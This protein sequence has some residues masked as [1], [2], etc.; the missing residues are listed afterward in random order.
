[1]DIRTIRQLTLLLS[2]VAGI[3]AC[4]TL[5]VRTGPVPEL[6]SP[7]EVTP[8]P[9][10]VP[11]PVAVQP[12]QQ[13]V[14]AVPLPP[15][16]LPPSQRVRKALQMLEQGEY[17]DARNQLN[18]ALQEKPGLQIADNLIQQIDAD[19]I[20]YLGVKNFYY[21]VESGDSLSTIAG[22]FLED[23]MKFVVLARYNK[24]ENPSKLAPGDR[25]R[26]PGAMPAD[27]WHKPKQKKKK[28]K[29]QRK[30]SIPPVERAGEE[31]PSS[32]RQPIDSPY[33]DG[34]D[35]IGSSGNEADVQ[36]VEMQPSP[37][38][39]ATLDQVLDKA[40]KLYA[41]GDLPAAISQLDSEG[42]R[43]ASAKAVQS[44]QIS[45]Y[46][47]YAKQL[48]R[49]DELEQARGL[50]EK[51]VLLDA[52]DEQAIKNLIQ[53]EDKLEARRLYRLGEDLLS[54]EQVENAY[55]MFTQS[56]TYDPTNEKARAAQGICRDKLTDGYH[57]EAMRHF[58]NQELAQAIVLWDKI[59]ALD[60]GHPLAP[61]YRARAMEMQLKLKQIESNNQ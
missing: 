32:P 13:T 45:Y 3:S 16:R 34:Q 52:A 36:Q 22:K 8:K 43:Y 25:I 42:G 19:P 15:D 28:K 55:A 27:L 40:R 5:V 4:Q 24:L 10:P 44:L 38:P 6:D 33:G 56:L 39:V 41:K 59:L 1:M 54:G 29:T 51:V 37:P 9:T 17:E 60:P 61:G 47:E 14:P 7:W 18:W 35:A 26:V 21:Q 2:I 30:P 20:D 23:P 46:S 57:R 48:V 12:P 11:E 58:R 53:I 31:S 50:L 49:E